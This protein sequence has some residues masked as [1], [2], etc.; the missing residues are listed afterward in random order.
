M[1]IFHE[2][3]LIAIRNTLDTRKDQTISTDTLIILAECILKN[4]ILDHDNSV[5]KEIR[6][7]AMGTKMTPP[8]AIISMGSI[9]NEILSNIL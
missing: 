9:E 7:T 5:F 2:E 6:R 8:Y 4:N 1:N 3:G